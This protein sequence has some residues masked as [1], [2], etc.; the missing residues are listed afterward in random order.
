VR[1]S[2]AEISCSTNG[3]SIAYIVSK[4]SGRERFWDGLD[5]MIREY[6]AWVKGNHLF[7]FGGMYERNY[8]YH[9]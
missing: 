3:S 7:Q 9:N 1:C 2:S 5:E 8:E 6:L 4:Q